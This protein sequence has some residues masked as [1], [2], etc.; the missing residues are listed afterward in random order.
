MASKAK[1]ITR[2][3][4]TTSVTSDNLNKGSEL[5]FAEMDSNLINLR[6]QTIG[7]V[8][9]DSSTI[10]IA[11]GD[12]LYIQGGTNVTTSTNS[13]GSVTINSTATASSLGDLTA[14]GSTLQSPSNADIVLEPGGTGDIHLKTDSQS[15]VKIGDSTS[16]NYFS[17]L[18]GSGIFRWNSSGSTDLSISHNNG[19]SVTIS[20]A[21]GTGAI[22]IAPTTTNATIFGSGSHNATL[23][24][25]GAHDLILN[26]N[27]GT[28][29]G[30]ITLTDGANGNITLAPNGTGS[31]VVNANI[32]STGT[33]STDGISIVDNEITAS[34]S[35]DNLNLTASGTGIIQ[36][37]AGTD[38]TSAGSYNVGT[39]QIHEASTSG[40]TRLFANGRTLEVALTGDTS[41]SNA[42][43]RIQD[44]ISLDMAGFDSTSSGTTKGAQMQHL[45]ELKNSASGNSQLAS[46]S[47]QATG[48]FITAG[49]SGNLTLDDFYSIRSFGLASGSVAGTTTVTDYYHMYADAFNT[50]ASGNVT[51]TNE[52]GFFSNVSHAS[53]K[54]AFYDNANGQSLF[55]D[56][57]IK[58]NTIQTNSSNADLEINTSGTGKTINSSA[59][60]GKGDQTGGN[61]ILTD[62]A[63]GS[64]HTAQFA[65][66]GMLNPSG[67]Q[68]DAAGSFHYP[69][70]VLNNFSSNANT[71]LWATRSKS[72]T[73]GD[74]TSSA[75]YLSSG[76]IIFQ[77]FASGTNGDTDGSEYF[78]GNTIV[79]LYASENHSV[80]ARGGGF[81]VK[82]INTGSV[83]GATQK[84]NIN[85]NVQIAN[86]KSGDA[87]TVTGGAGIDYVQITDNKITT[88]ASNAD[89]EISANGTGQ[90]QLSPNDAKVDDVFSN[91]G[92]Y[93]FGANRI[94]S[95]QNADANAI[96]S[97]S[98]D[99]RYSNGDFVSVSLGSSSSNSHAR[100]RSGTFSLIDMNGFSITSSAKY[101]KG[102]VTRYAE[103]M[104]VN[105]STSTAST[106]NNVT[107]VYSS[108][109][110]TGTDNGG[111]LTIT[112]GYGFVSDIFLGEGTSETVAMTNAYYN[113]VQ[114][115]SGNGAITNEYAYHIEDSLGGTNKY[116]FWDESNSLSMFGAVILQNQS[117][118]PS[119]VTNASHIYAK[120]DGG[121]SEVH[122]RDEA[123]NVTKISP[124]N[125]AG[126]W[127]FYS[128]NT[129]TGK[130]VRINME[131]MIRKLE[132]ITGETFIEGE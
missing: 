38:G 123:G 57:L 50:G 102:I 34:R 97:S 43:Y 124:H 116:A 112:S 4:T 31:V 7:I 81:S 46:S 45:V 70:L 10:D 29:A 6:D 62:Q 11:A 37:G 17:F 25:N 100:W 129:K 119:G 86:P 22:T 71:A 75:A 8:A 14:T 35:N 67:L 131:K 125:E 76:D 121:S 20:E 130:T 132:N 48:L 93:D 1:L 24:S 83:S 96:F 27:S 101:F 78:N 104:V 66:P 53:N 61:I 64:F 12:K 128:K 109:N 5:T 3:A 114:G 44:T 127:E 69:Q 80:S 23:T 19:G 52:Y 117:G 33:I 18:P 105:N 56:I 107:G 47:G 72:N 59:Y 36:L 41:S 126:E 63:D 13:D 94:F 9:D 54:Y 40:S 55:G 120:D 95:E 77:F 42:R 49:G 32:T 110:T 85:D 106:L 68:I 26:T 99:R 2:Q 39:L 98:S 15:D 89:L 74:S 87:L 113:S 91:D 103:N 60:I 51:V 90:I 88:N 92:K 115:S 79:D 73:H 118:D 122:V 65:S 58:Q 30:S 111:G 28:N 16:N 108:L 21:G 84:L 82:T